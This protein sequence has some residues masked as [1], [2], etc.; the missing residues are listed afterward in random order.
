[1]FGFLSQFTMPHL[2]QILTVFEFG[3]KFSRTTIFFVHT[4]SLDA[5]EAV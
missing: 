4:G 2:W 5:K 3:L 1:M